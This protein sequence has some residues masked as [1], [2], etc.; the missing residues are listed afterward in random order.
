MDPLAMGDPGLSGGFSEY[1]ATEISAAGEVAASLRP[2]VVNGAKGGHGIQGD[3]RTVAALVHATHAGMNGDEFFRHTIVRA[4]L[5]H[6]VATT[7]ATGAGWEIGNR[8]DDRTT[9]GTAGNGDDRIAE[10][11]SGWGS[12]D[13]TDRRLLTSRYSV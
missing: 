7:A 8:R 4:K 1:L 12:P 13:L 6:E 5:D 10:G 2:R 3:A 9:A 11:C